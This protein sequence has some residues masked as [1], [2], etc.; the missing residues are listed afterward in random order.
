M[1]TVNL[2]QKAAQHAQI[3]VGK[4]VD[5]EKNSENLITKTLGV[6][7]E[8]GVYACILY[9]F[10]RSSD[11][12]I[13]AKHI[14]ASLYGLLNEI[15]H[16]NSLSLDDDKQSPKDVLKTFTDKVCN[17]LDN[18]LLVKDVY[19]QALIYARF[20]AKAFKKRN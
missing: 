8:Q 4:C 9:L 17:D 5:K 19:E 10:S 12:Q 2:D 18:L 1:A 16:Y 6:L 11:D 7:Q 14:R 3:M 13:M 20:T 15:P